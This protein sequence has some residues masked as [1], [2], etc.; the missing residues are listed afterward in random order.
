MLDHISLYVGTIP[1]SKL[2]TINLIYGHM[3]C[4]QSILEIMI[5][6]YYNK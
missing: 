2:T 1:K 6:N 3:D 5:S 4:M